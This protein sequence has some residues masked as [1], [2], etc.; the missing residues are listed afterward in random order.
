MPRLNYMQKPAI[1]EREV[2]FRFIFTTR[3]HDRMPR[4]SLCPWLHY[5]KLGEEW[6]PS[7][8]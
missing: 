3:L 7:V 1:G 8:T 4:I 6:G 5:L 2:I